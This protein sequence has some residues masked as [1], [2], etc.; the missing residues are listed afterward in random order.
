MR[1]SPELR[2]DKGARFSCAGSFAAAA[3]APQP[4]QASNGSAAAASPRQPRPPSPSRRA[5]AATMPVQALRCARAS[6][7]RARHAC[8]ICHVPTQ[9]SSRWKLAGGVLR[10]YIRLHHHQMNKRQFSDICMKTLVLWMQGAHP[11]EVI[12]AS[13]GDAAGA[14][15]CRAALPG[16]RQGP[17][18]E[19][20]PCLGP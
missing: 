7:T 9:P 16:R 3:A 18:A 5:R 6:M 17:L 14:Q 15:R 1:C 2:K 12:L 20:A 10:A 4:V 13:A 19:V 11:A 8:R